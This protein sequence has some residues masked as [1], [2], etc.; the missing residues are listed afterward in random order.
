M[1]EAMKWLEDEREARSY[2]HTLAN[3]MHEE[4]DGM[5]TA[6]IR[7][8][9]WQHRRHQKAE[10]KELL[11][12]QSELKSEIDGKNQALQDVRDLKLEAESKV[13]HFINKQ[14]IVN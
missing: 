1:T 9:D 13:I 4:L 8:S 3:K 14:L 12:L 6:T 5:K 2:L 7:K 10:K 11:A